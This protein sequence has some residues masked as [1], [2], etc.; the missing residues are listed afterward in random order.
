MRPLFVITFIISLLFS[1]IGSVMAFLI[2]YEEY[3]HH[4]TD[5]KRPFQ[6]AMQ[7]AIFTFVVFLVLTILAVSFLAYPK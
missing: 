5:K 7:T 2:T 3:A 6:H 4:Y 1:L